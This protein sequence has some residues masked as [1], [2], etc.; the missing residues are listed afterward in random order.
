[1]QLVETDMT[2]FYRRLATIELSTDQHTT[3]DAELIAPL[4]VR[5]RL[6]HPPR[7]V[8]DPLKRHLA[9]FTHLYKQEGSDLCSPSLE[10]APGY[11]ASRAQGRTFTELER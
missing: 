7:A 11:D 4:V 9:S 1:M 3:T 6:A 5:R 10:R 2:I 8:G